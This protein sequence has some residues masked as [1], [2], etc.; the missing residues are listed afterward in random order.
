ML[1]QSVIR[2]GVISPPSGAS[3]VGSMIYDIIFANP[4][5][6]HGLD[7]C[8]V[9]LETIPALLRSLELLETPQA[10]IAESPTLCL[11]PRDHAQP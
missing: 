2:H 6:D 4:E 10:L 3:A 5:L 9:E 7:Q 1:M 8:S 11:L